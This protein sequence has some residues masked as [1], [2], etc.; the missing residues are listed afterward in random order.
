MS[1]RYGADRRIPETF[2]RDIEFLGTKESM[3]FHGIRLMYYTKRAVVGVGGRTEAMALLDTGKTHS[4]GT[5]AA[6]KTKEL[7]KNFDEFITKVIYQ[8][9]SNIAPD[10]KD[11]D[12]NVKRSIEDMPRLLKMY[13]DAYREIL[14]PQLTV[15]KTPSETD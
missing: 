12:E 6:Q 11:L 9:V 3:F 13:R 5:D 14:Q 7:V 1:R 2:C 8:D 10:V 15:P 4:F